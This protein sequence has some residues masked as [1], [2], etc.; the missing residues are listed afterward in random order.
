MRQSRGTV[1]VAGLRMQFAAA[2]ARTGSTCRCRSR[3]LAD[4]PAGVQLQVRVLDE[5]PGAARE[6][7]LP[8]QDQGMGRG[9]TGGRILAA[10]APGRV[11]QRSRCGYGRNPA[12]SASSR[13]PPPA[14]RPLEIPI[15]CPLMLPPAAALTLARPLARWRC[16]WR[17]PPWPPS[18]SRPRRYPRSWRSAAPQPNG[19]RCAGRTARCTARPRWSRSLTGGL[20][21]RAAA[22]RPV[23]PYPVPDPDQ[24]GPNPV[25]GLLL[26]S[27]GLL[28]GMTSSGSR[29]SRRTPAAR[30]SASHPT[31]AGSPSCTSSRASRRSTSVSARSMTTAPNPETELVEGSDGCL[32]GV[33]R[34]G[35]TN[36]T[37]VVF[38]CRRTGRASPSC[39]TFGPITVGRPR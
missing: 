13:G 5:A 11:R 22:R 7:E 37:G 25:G 36:G 29:C 20:I 21:Y 15:R 38:S 24:R 33:T 31:A 32:Y 9:W 30:C 18:P 26:G 19:A 35:G 17:V 28:Y 14:G 27:D 10:P 12:Q 8:E 23:D 3:R 4:P 16:S 6:R 34:A 1:A 2:A 39:T